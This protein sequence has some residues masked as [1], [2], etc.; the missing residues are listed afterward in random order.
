MHMESTRVSME[1]SRK[2]QTPL[3]EYVMAIQQKDNAIRS[4]QMQ[5]I[6]EARAH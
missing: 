3:V 1:K 4:A 5:A 2:G 6:E